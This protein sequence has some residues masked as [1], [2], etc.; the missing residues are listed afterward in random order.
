M[1][2]MLLSGMKSYA[3]D[4]FTSQLPT[5]VETAQP[6]IE[7]ALRKSLRTMRTKNP[8]SSKI[9]ADNWAKLNTAVQQ[10]LGPSPPIFGGVKKRTRKALV[11]RRSK[12]V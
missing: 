4:A 12:H 7:D 10:E 5:L 3:V 6:Q 11:R 8:Q 9:F 1:A 2:G